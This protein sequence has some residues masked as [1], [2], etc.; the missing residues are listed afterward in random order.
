MLC[1]AADGLFV[2]AQQ[3]T[4][5]TSN[6][7]QQEMSARKS[8]S[9]SPAPAKGLDP[10]DYK[11]DAIALG[12]CAALAYASIDGAVDQN[13]VTSLMSG[14]GTLPY[15]GKSAVLTLHTLNTCQNRGSKFWV[16]DLMECVAS[17]FAAGI[18]LNLLNGG[19]LGEALMGGN[20]NDYTFVAICWYLQNHS[21]A[22][23]VPNLWEMVTSSPIGAP[24]QKVMDLATL[25]F[26]NSIIFKAASGGPAADALNVSTVALTPLIKA[27]LVAGANSAIPAKPANS[28]TTASALTI[29]VLASTS[30]LSTL[31]VVGE[32]VAKITSTVTGAIPL[33]LDTTQQIYTNCVVFLAFFGEI[34]ATLGV[35]AEVLSPSGTVAGLVNKVLN[36]KA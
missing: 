21:I 29:A 16:T 33:N 8:R 6:T 19:T 3:S 15:I 36:L 25:C 12:L 4:F 27:T 13:S 10:M 2:R 7:S 31:P 23:A 18:A 22:G 30:G 26:V 32:S 5:N 35:P 14:A 20:E 17:V 11:D 1:T 9:K 34:L 24:L 28:A